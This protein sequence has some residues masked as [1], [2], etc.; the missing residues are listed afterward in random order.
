MH[1]KIWLNLMGS[2]LL[3]S[4]LSLSSATL[5]YEVYQVRKGDTLESVAKRFGIEVADLKEANKFLETESLKPHQVL[6]IPLRQADP[7]SSGKDSQIVS[8]TVIPGRGSASPFNQM[9]VAAQTSP[10]P[11]QASSTGTPAALPNNGG[12]SPGASRSGRRVGVLGLVR[13]SGAKIR[14]SPRTGGAVVYSCSKGTQLVIVGQKG[15]WYGVMMID[16]SICWIERAAVD[17]TDVELVQSSPQPLQGGRLDIVQAALAW[18]GTPY[19]YGGTTVQGI[20]CSGLVMNVFRQFGVRLPRTAREQ[21]RIGQPVSW[22]Q[23]LPGDRLYFSTDGRSIDHTGLYM[24]EGQFVH[25]SGRRGMVGID[26]LA[27]PSYWR[28]FV[29]AKR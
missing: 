12:P 22:D 8:L 13:R 18:L 5:T 21:Y 7:P 9:Q 20:D 29:G 11:S 25:A 28:M 6:T 19:R 17:L 2:S 15:S 23:L 26:S 3:L 24:G 10:P 4:L 16:G 1:R 14:S 27:D